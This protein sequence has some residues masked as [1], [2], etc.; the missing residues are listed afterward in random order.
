MTRTDLR[1]LADSSC[2]LELPHLE[3]QMPLL[4]G[5]CHLAPLLGLLG[6]F[7]GL[8]EAF[9]AASSTGGPLNTTLLTEGIYQALIAAASGIMIAIPAYAAFLYLSGRI[10]RIAQEMQRAAFELI[11]VLTVASDSARGIIEFNP[12][13]STSDRSE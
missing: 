4:A 12:K 3:R 9:S 7:L 6:T 10:N 11:N 5:I 13:R 2:N 1:E 8:L